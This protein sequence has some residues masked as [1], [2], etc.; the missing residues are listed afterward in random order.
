MAEEQTVDQATQ[1]LEQGATP[2][3]VYSQEDVNRVG[4]KEHKSGYTKAV[5]DLGFDDFET[6][7]NALQAYNE[8]QASQKSEAEKQ[9]EVIAEKEKA[10]ED[11]LMAN[12]TLEAKLSALSAGVN[13]ESVEDV[14]ALAQRSVNEETTIDQAIK[15]VIEKYPQFAKPPETNTE[16]PRPNI[17]VGGNPAVGKGAS[18]DPF[19]RVI[20]EYEKK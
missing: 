4:T 2:E 9:S 8:W 13:A 1:D 19:Q 5:R 14:I 20:E 16:A 12:K 3:K 15:L 18:L 17:V 10:L 11:A 6:A 7:K